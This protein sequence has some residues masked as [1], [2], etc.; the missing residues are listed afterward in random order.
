M[1][2]MDLAYPVDATEETMDG[3]ITNFGF[4]CK[5]LGPTLMNNNGW[6]LVSYTS[7]KMNTIVAGYILDRE[8]QVFGNIF[9]KKSRQPVLV[10]GADKNINLDSDVLRENSRNVVGKNR[11]MKTD[12][13]NMNYS[14]A[15][16]IFGI[17]AV[18]TVRF[19]ALPLSGFSTILIL[20]S[21][22]RISL[23]INENGN[24]RVVLDSSSGFWLPSSS[25][26]VSVNKDYVIKLYAGRTIVNGLSGFVSMSIH[27]IDSVTP[28]PVEEGNFINCN[29]FKYFF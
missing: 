14:D 29:F 20:E 6:A 19:T 4:L 27:E 22:K 11:Y 7:Q 8:S 28:A 24:F 1:N 26:V 2:R 10:N 17:S 23:E 18:M 13:M 3:F 5:P 15:I 9:E 21:D 12:I 25:M 16:F